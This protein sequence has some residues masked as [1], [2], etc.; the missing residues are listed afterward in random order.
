MRLTSGHKSALI[1]TFVLAS[2]AGCTNVPSSSTAGPAAGPT[3]A[4]LAGQ[5]FAEICIAQA[6]TFAGSQAA[7]AARGFTQN[8]ITK[9]FYLTTENLSVKLLDSRDADAG[10]LNFDV[11][12][13][14]DT[15]SMVFGTNVDGNT[16]TAQ[17]AQGTA[18]VLSTELP[19]GITITSRPAGGLTLMNARIKAQ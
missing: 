4:V 15:C 8:A 14:P 7:M 13:N 18:S 12:A 3:S 16:A 5:L 17:M 1:A 9:T 10:R 11:P 19:S 2:V 6:P